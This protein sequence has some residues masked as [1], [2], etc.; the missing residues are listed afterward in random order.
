MTDQPLELNPNSEPSLPGA[1]LHEAA[2][3]DMFANLQTAYAELTETKV[4][5]ERRVVEIDDIRDL[6][7]RVVESMSEAL[8]LMD[9][10]G[11]VIQVN[12]A[13]GRLLA[14]DKAELT[15]QLLPDLLAASDIP[16]TPWDLLGRSPQGMLSDLDVEVQNQAGRSIPLSLSCGLVRDRRGK[17]TGLLVVARDITE[18][19]QAEAA[20]AER[21]TALETIARVSVAASTILEPQELL[22]TVVD[23]TQQRFGF[24]HVHIYL[25]DQDRDVLKLTAGAGDIGRQLVA[26]QW[27]IALNSPRSLVARAA[28]SKQAVVV[29][30]VREAADWL[31]N[32]L[33]PETQ[34]EIAVPILL[35]A[36]ETVLGVLDVQQNRLDHLDEGVAEVLQSLANQIAVA[37]ANARLFEQTAEAKQIAEQASQAK[38]D[39]LAKMSHELRTP[40]NGILG[41]AQILKRGGALSEWQLNGLN[42]MHQSAE[43]LLT[44]INDILD[45]AK[46]EAGKL[47][48]YPTEV[49]LP[50]CLQGLAGLVRLSAEQKG[51][52][53]TYEAVTPLPAVVMAD[54]KRL[55]QVLLNL[56][57][58]AIKFTDQGTVTLRAAV[59]DEATGTIRFEVADT[60]IGMTRAQLDKIFL[61]FEQVGEI[62]RQSQ[63]TGLG[64]AISQ[65]LA[66]AMGSNLQ[67]ESAAGRG[68]T[69]WLELQLPVVEGQT[70][71]GLKL[72]QTVVGYQGARLKILVVD[73]QPHNRSVLVN[74]LEPLG[75]EII[76]ATDGQHSIAQ[77]QVI[78]PDLIIMD[79]GLP[80][81]SSAEA[82]RA[83]RQ[84]PV[85]QARPPLIFASSANAYAETQKDREGLFDDF[86]VKPID[87]NRLLTLLAKHLAL[88]W[89]YADPAPAQS[90]VPSS[91]PDSPEKE[92]PLVPPPLAELKILFDLALKGHLRGIQKRAAQL[93]RTD[94]KLK[95]FARQ[96][97]QLAKNF[98]EKQIRTLIK[99]YMPEE[100]E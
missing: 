41:Y 45:L 95:P 75:F 19:K 31:P 63:G 54:E 51:L 50:P 69:F 53:F 48:L 70:T 12:Q 80:D 36:E 46:I 65:E 52:T 11:R 25:L 72:E 10:T 3:P 68:T 66:R 13:A 22:Q 16:A 59:A 87:L 18:R 5:L 58:N 92:S 24:Y 71:A 100:S 91:A 82:T 62:P 34:A 89:V 99:Q 76:E 97:Q 90:A 21:A 38:S 44:L 78:Q 49:H 79:L 23:L 37:L 7:E 14:R 26:Q 27:H 40:L 96:V 93:E 60:G 4:E 83:I 15:G 35:G 47:E 77:A 32:A 88:E 2:W 64:L 42:I 43:H 30:Q 39:F 61:P 17:V 73:D 55:R 84:L 86:L 67:V 1:A 56:L 6:F 8:F 85:F 9:V 98:D 29:N 94:Q 28:R 81:Q 57:S 20:L 74:I 33:L